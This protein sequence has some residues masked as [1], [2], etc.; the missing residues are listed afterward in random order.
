MRK[1]LFPDE[2][3]GRRGDIALSNLRYDP[4]FVTFEDNW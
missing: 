2:V 4:L 1:A 3:A